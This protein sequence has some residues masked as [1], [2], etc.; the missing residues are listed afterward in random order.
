MKEYGEYWT[1]VIAAEHEPSCQYL[2]RVLSISA[3][4][5][6][7]ML[8]YSQTWLYNPRKDQ[9]ARIF[10]EFNNIIKDLKLVVLLKAKFWQGTSD[11]NVKPTTE[12]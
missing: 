4:R 9:P 12:N 2:P 10:D 6:I 8:V 1:K 5:E 11:E 3:N 7:L